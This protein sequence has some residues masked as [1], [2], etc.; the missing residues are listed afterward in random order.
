M[1]EPETPL[2]SPPGATD[3]AGY[4]RWN[5]IYLA[6]VIYTAALIV[7]LWIFSITFTS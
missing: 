3:E 2:P 5:R 7:G 6:I 4:L 1:K